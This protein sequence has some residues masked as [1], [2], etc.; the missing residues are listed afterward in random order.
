MATGSSTPF[1]FANPTIV[2][3]K[4]RLRLVFKE[5][6]KIS[7]K[8]DSAGALSRV[9]DGVMYVKDVRACSHCN[10][11]DLGTEDIKSMYQFVILGDSGTI[12]PKFKAIEDLGLTGILYI[13][14]FKDE[15]IKYVLTRV[16]N[17]FIWLDMPYMITKE[18]IR[19]V[20]NLPRVGQEPGKKISNTEVEK[21]TTVTHDT[22]SMRIST[23]TNM[24]IK[25]ASMMIGYKVIQSN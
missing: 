22:R 5:V 13:L 15:L 25:F 20:T 21:L 23:I 9:P 2:E 11:E 17:E 10:L 6:P 24:D 16:H 7:I 4:D 12:K 3:V 1:F 14:E 18:A 8:E 19:D